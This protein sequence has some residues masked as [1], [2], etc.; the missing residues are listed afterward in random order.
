MTF[1]NIHL[2]RANEAYKL[3]QRLKSVRASLDADLSIIP[4]TYASLLIRKNQSEVSAAAEAEG[5]FA[6][7]GLFHHPGVEAHAREII[8]VLAAQSVR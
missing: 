1:L 4:I 6:L 8:K 5:A 2:E 3:L 7:V